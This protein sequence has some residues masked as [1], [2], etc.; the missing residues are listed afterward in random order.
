MGES[1]SVPTEAEN[2]AAPTEVKLDV[3]TDPEGGKQKTSLAPSSKGGVI[4]KVVSTQHRDYNLV[5][6]KVSVPTKVNYIKTHKMKGHK[7][8]KKGIFKEKT[9]LLYS[10]TNIPRLLYTLASH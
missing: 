1:M 8:I 2:V 9:R 7:I 5:S 6:K 3:T 10:F 4:V